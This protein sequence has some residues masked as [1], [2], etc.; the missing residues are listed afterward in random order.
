LSAPPPPP[1]NGTLYENV[2]KYGRSRQATDGNMARAHW[3]LDNKVL[4]AHTQSM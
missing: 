1:P 3:L 2:E 4:Q